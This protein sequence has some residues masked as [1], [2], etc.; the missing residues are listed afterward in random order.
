MK[1]KSLKIHIQHSPING[2]PNEWIMDM[3][4]ETGTDRKRDFVESS[5][6]SAS[7]ETMMLG[8]P[9]ALKSMIPEL[10]LQ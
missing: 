7:C 2:D 4:V 1:L 8:I 6:K 10:V 9:E 3:R 5:W